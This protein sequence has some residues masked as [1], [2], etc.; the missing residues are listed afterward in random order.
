MSNL[1]VPVNYQPA[2]VASIQQGGRRHKKHSKKA[3]ATPE[4]NDYDKNIDQLE[5]GLGPVNKEDFP[6]DIFADEDEYVNIESEGVPVKSGGSRKRKYKRHTKKRS[7]KKRRVT[8][9]K[10]HRR[11]RK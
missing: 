6:V 1:T 8:R 9:R 3:G 11:N 2:P 4:D 10:T 7:Q 5:K